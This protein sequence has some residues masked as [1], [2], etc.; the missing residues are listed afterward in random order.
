MKLIITDTHYESGLCDHPVT[1][2][3]QFTNLKKGRVG[4]RFN[5]TQHDGMCEEI[6]G[7]VDLQDL[8]LTVNTLEALAKEQKKRGIQLETYQQ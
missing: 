3:I 4:I 7:E 6:K 1:T 5:R 8:V 2:Y